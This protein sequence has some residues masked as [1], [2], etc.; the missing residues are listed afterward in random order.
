[1]VPT[2]RPALIPVLTTHML[3][4]VTAIAQALPEEGSL[5]SV[6][7]LAGDR[8]FESL[9]L[10]RRVRCELMSSTASPRFLWKATSRRSAGTTWLISPMRSASTAVVRSPA[11]KYSLA[12]AKPM[13]CGQI[14]APPSPATRPVLTCGSPILAWSAAMKDEGY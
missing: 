12:R 5:E 3:G 10:Q 13:S 2:D 9:P 6:D 8:G 1:M 14:S 11:N 7:Y 4:E